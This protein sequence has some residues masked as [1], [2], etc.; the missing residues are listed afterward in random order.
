[1]L[2][3]DIA[4]FPVLVSSSFSL[5]RP[6]TKSLSYLDKPQRP[7]TRSRLALPQACKLLI[8][9]EHLNAPLFHFLLDVSA[10]MVV[11]R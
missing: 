8:R 7:C 10:I 4:L 6:A 2:F 3:Y 5:P 11:R 9:K 1:M